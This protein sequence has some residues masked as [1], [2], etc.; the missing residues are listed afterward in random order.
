MHNIPAAWEQT[1][2]STEATKQMGMVNIHT[3]SRMVRRCS[4]PAAW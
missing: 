2:Q 3:R 4:I 1:S